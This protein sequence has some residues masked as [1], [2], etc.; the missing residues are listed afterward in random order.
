M[1]WT[2]GKPYVRSGEIAVPLYDVNMRTAWLS[3]RIEDD[4]A[5]Q[6]RSTIPNSVN[7]AMAHFDSRSVRSRAVAYIL[8]LMQNIHYLTSMTTI[9]VHM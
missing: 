1:N 7:P 9:S 3:L 6:L 5:D 8:L 2:G 4:R